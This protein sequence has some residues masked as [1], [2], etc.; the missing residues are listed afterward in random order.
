MKIFLTAVI[1]LLLTGCAV[2]NLLP[3]QQT[4]VYYG[5]GS[6][7]PSSQKSVFRGTELKVLHGESYTVPF[8]GNVMVNYWVA[9]PI[10]EPAK[11][12]TNGGLFNEQIGHDQTF[13]VKT[14]NGWRIYYTTNSTQLSTTTFIK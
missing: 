7:V 11:N 14:T 10:T 4:V 12:I 1:V 5:M 2:T 13:D 3:E 8:S 6:T 9:E